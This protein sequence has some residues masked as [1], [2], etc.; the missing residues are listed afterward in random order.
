MKK[1]I[2]IVA[3][4]GL[5]AGLLAAAP[6]ADDLVAAQKD[7]IAAFKAAPKKRPHVAFVSNG[8]ADFWT[9]AKAG[10]IAAGKSKD[11]DCDVTVEFP[12]GGL[13]DQK[14][15]LE[16]LV[17]KGIDGISVSPI[18]PTNQ[19]EVLD[20]VAGKSLLITN[21]SDAP[22][23]PRLCYIGMDNYEAGLMCGKLAREGCKGGKVAIFIGR[24]EQ[25][26]AKRRRQGFIDG[27][28]DRSPDPTRYD[29]PSKVFTENGYTVVGTWTDSFD[30]AKAK[31]NIE[32]VIIKHPDLALMTGLFEY[33]ST[34]AVEVL[35]QTGKV[36]KIQLAAF[37][38]GADVIAA[39]REGFV[40]GTVVQ[41]PYGYGY[42]SVKVLNAFCKG[43]MSMVPANGVINI[44]A[45]VIRKDNAESFWKDLKAKL[46]AGKDA[47]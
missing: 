13:G 31:A 10:A 23:A 36:G 12:G 16:D 41:D 22:N 30:R 8:V 37:D 1:L 24:L 47:K 35:R 17:I 5:S 34:L 21:D 14:R 7:R 33:N 3:L 27:L 26:N 18:D 2:S 28:L 44:P 25:D 9:I 29:E 32:D 15:M 42:E 43:D 19:A 39:I 45:R 46:K 11:I 20:L 40:L 4:A 6:A 38:E